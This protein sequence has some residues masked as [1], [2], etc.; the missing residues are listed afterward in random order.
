M[1]NLTSP[2]SDSNYCLD[3]YQ[4]LAQS[5]PDH[6]AR[7]GFVHSD[8]WKMMVQ[9]IHSVGEDYLATL[10]VN[11][12]GWEP[13]G[14]YGQGILKTPVN[15]AWI[16]G[17]DILAVTELNDPVL[18]FFEKEELLHEMNGDWL[19]SAHL[20]PDEDILWIAGDAGRKIIA[21][22][23]TFKEHVSLDLEQQLPDRKEARHLIN[24]ARHQN[25]L[26]LILQNDSTTRRT[27]CSIDLNAPHARAVIHPSSVLLW[28]R[29]FVVWKGNL[30][31]T[32]HFFPIIERLESTDFRPWK[33]T[34]FSHECRGAGTINGCI[35]IAMQN[36]LY[37]C[38]ATG[39]PNSTIQLNSAHKTIN[40][41]SLSPTTSRSG[42]LAILDLQDPKVR[43]FSTSG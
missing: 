38:D 33:R 14:I 20:W 2:D 42:L 41:Q 31:L 9:R 10:P 32:D 19:R 27:I 35:V 11:S 4:A 25:R 26:Y 8:I 30:F 43:V 17:S 13:A 15:L 3:T 34:V 1:N 29:Q 39:D 6:T 7:A 36:R 24:F 37:S 23:T 22:D 18:H 16:S 21:I 28:P 40:V 12:V 5:L